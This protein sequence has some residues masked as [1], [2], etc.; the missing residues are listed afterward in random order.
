MKKYRV[1]AEMNLNYE[2]EAESEEEAREIAEEI[3]YEKMQFLGMLN[4]NFIDEI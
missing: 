3:S 1:Y 2:I 4:I